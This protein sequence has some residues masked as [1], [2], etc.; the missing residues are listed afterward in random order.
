MSPLQQHR[1]K[2]QPKLPPLLELLDHIV[3]EKE[4]LLDHVGELK[5]LFPHTNQQPHI[6]FKKGVVAV[7]SAAVK[8]GVVFSGGQAPGGHNV[9]S[10]LFDALKKINPGCN[11]IG[12]CDGP[13]GILKNKWIVI[14]QDKL[15]SYRNQGGFDLIGSSRT[16]IETPEQFAAAEATVRTLKL[17]GLVIV[18]GDDSNTNAALLAEYFLAKGVTT[19]VVGVPKTIDG[20]L[21]NEFIDISFGFDTACKTYSETI[22]NILK[23]ALS[24]KKY[25]YFIKLMGRTAS[26]I[27]LECALQ[28]HPNMSLIGEEIAREEK[29][30]HQIVTE[31]ADMICIR[32]EKGKNYGAILI[33]EGLIEFIPEFSQ[34]IQELNTLMATGGERDVVISKLSPQASQ[35]FNEMPATIQNQLLLDRDSHGNV[36][37]SKIETER[38]LLEL[39]EKE[40]QKRHQEGRYNGKFSTQPLFFG[41]E[42]RAG[43]PSNFDSDYCYALGHVAAL[44]IRSGLTGYIC[45]ITCLNRPVDQWQVRGI[46]LYNML[47]LEMREG[48][49]KPV[50]KKALVDLSG[51]HFNE[52]IAN[53]E[54]WKWEDDYLCPGP[55]QFEG[56]SELTNQPP[57]TIG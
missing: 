47:H 13:S 33:P 46:P 45:C 10:G 37:I 44:L 51:R 54:K 11:L 15:V 18:G 38:L 7:K 31:I 42:G 19:R 49:K 12:F 53:R 32:A 9:I 26:H 2:Y 27:T 48:K 23:D 8:V 4:S 36:Q 24:A 6:S 29:S 30:L 55:I 41:Y 39:V 17:D 52:F 34:M 1:M 21:R 22:G 14:D 43:L 5:L 28:T 16:K 3:V 50:I 35:C 40:L 56:P 57:L 25:Y 20:D